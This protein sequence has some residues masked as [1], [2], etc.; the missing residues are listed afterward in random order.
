LPRERAA[1]KRFFMSALSIPP[2]HGKAV[3]IGGLGVVF[4]LFGSDTAGR[5]AVVEHPI[6]PGTLAAPPHTHQHEDEASYVLEGEVTAEVGAEIVRA[7]A[8]TLI[9][10]PKGV[11]HTFWNEGSARARVLEIISPGGFER[12]FEELAELVSKGGPPD[13]PRLMD[14]AARYGLTLD[15]S[16]VG[17]LSQRYG[18][19]LGGP[20]ATRPGDP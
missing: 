18:V 11:P 17:A 9:Y 8:G 12:Y 19:T 4:K 15:M 6:T 5:F 1:D 2:G 10:K 3:S 20:P 16:R 7:R 13:V 14:L